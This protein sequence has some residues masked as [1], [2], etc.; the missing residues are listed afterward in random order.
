MPSGKVDQTAFKKEAEDFKQ[1]EETQRQEG[2]MSLLADSIRDKTAKSYE[3][4]VW[5]YELINGKIEVGRPAS[6]KGILDYLNVLSKA[7]SVKPSTLQGYISA[8]KTVSTIRTAVVFRQEEDALINRAV[9]AAKLRLA[10]RESEPKKASPIPAQAIRAMANMRLQEGTFD[11]EIRDAV[12]VGAGLLLRFGSLAPRKCGDIS[13]CEEPAG[14]V[15]TLN[16]G[17][18]KTALSERREVR[19]TKPFSCSANFCIAHWLRR[20]ALRRSSEEFIFKRVAGW[21]TEKFG[22]VMRSTMRRWYPGK[23][24][25]WDID[26]LSAHS[27]RHTG[28]SLLVEEGCQPSEV[29]AAGGWSQTSSAWQGYALGALRRKARDHASLILG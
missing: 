17:L 20:V 16:L 7:G 4:A 15:V 1:M 29:K 21:S 22:N 23:I 13:Y 28:A 25:E 10:H 12:L 2:R 27:L 9:K 3:T 14:L 19:C 26:Q 11:E 5:Q 24:K 18:S 8:V 6:V